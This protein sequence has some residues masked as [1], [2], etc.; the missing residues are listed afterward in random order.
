MKCGIHIY[1]LCIYTTVGSDYP[2]ILLKVIITSKNH[3]Q[4]LILSIKVYNLADKNRLQLMFTRTNN[5]VTQV[6]TNLALLSVI[7]CKKQPQ[8][9]NRYISCHD[10]R[11]S[12]PLECRI[13]PSCVCIPGGKPL[14][15]KIAIK[16]CLHL[17]GHMYIY[18]YPKTCIDTRAVL[19]S[20]DR[21]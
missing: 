20:R 19:V 9:N 1:I 12:T 18:T 21:N 10:G 8:G 13:T 4:Y 14:V 16:L 11:F 2:G 15:Y 3:Y 7:Y 6:W 5:I 17:H